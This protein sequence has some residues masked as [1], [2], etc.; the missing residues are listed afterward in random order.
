MRN[1]VLYGKHLVQELGLSIY[2]CTTTTTKNN[3]LYIPL[4]SSG[5]SHLNSSFLTQ[6]ALLMPDVRQQRGLFIRT[7]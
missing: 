7:V 3:N 2:K 4:F 1:H 6:A 5:R